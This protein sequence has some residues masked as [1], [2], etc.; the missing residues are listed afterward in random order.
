[1]TVVVKIG[2]ARAVDPEGA[3]SDIG[4][5]IEAGEPVVVVHGGSTAVDE[6]L[7]RLDIEPDY[8]ET[9][10]GVVGRFT[11]AETMDV[12]KMVFGKLNVDLVTQ[13]QAMGVNAIG[14]SGPDGQVLSGTRKSAVR[15]LEDGK[16]KIRRGDH[17]GTI[18]SVNDDLL[19]LL[20]EAGYTPVVTVP[21][22][23]D[24]GTAVN[25][26]ADRAAAAV[27][28]ALGATL[29][30]LTD[31][32]GV[33]RDPDDSTTRIETVESPAEFDELEAAAEGFMG[34]KVMAAEEAL[35]SGATAVIIAD[36]NA[37]EPIHRALDGDGTT[38]RASALEEP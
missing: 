18:E 19:E 17:S 24:E 13:L 8:V 9:P 28:G 22:Y 29:V 27:A 21:M 36:A 26:D 15:V 31:V 20:I 5:L 11:D 7:E 6:T 30:E 3:L 4:S 33:Y 38:I 1:M 32:S 23:A 35:Q 34:R 37:E 25:S 12:F 2:G 10:S 16:R 14:L